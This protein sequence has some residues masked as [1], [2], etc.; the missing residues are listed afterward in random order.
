MGTILWPKGLILAEGESQKQK[1]SCYAWNAQAAAK[2][3]LGVCV[4]ICTLFFL[5]RVASRKKI[6]ELPKLLQ[7]DCNGHEYWPKQAG[8]YAVRSGQQRKLG[9]GPAYCNDGNQKVQRQKREP[10]RLG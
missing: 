1:H 4:A 7:N 10:D 3:C 6:D 5:L 8:K 2:C 9:Y